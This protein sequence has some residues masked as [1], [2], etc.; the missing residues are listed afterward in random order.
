MV[1]EGCLTKA[2]EKV[3]AMEDKGLITNPQAALD[4]IDADFVRQATPEA[5]KAVQDKVISYLAG[6]KMAV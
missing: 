1:L 5:P 3:E 4:L 6:L 2:Y